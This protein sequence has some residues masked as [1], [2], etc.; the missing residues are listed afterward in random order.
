MHTNSNC[1]N[2]NFITHNRSET[3]VVIVSSYQDINSNF[4]Y[5]THPYEI[6]SNYNNLH[7][8]PDPCVIDINGVHIGLTS[9]DVIGHI[10]DQEYSLYVVTF[11]YDY[12]FINSIFLISVTLVMIKLNVH[13]ILC[14]TRKHF[15]H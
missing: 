15:I 13:L 14:S 11:Y 5:P 1:L 9:T 8:V 4:V 12:S 10:A 2:I 7:L 6:Q 3:H